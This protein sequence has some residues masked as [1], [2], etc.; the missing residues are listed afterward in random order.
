MERSP[1]NRFRKW[2]ERNGWWNDTAE[3]E[4]RNSVKKQASCCFKCLFFFYPWQFK[5]TGKTCLQL[6]QAIQ[7]AEK[8]EKPPLTELFTDVYDKPPANLEE[9]EKLLRESISKHPED[10]PSKVPT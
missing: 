10:Y 2:V 3:S 5:L 1:V 9:Q 4:L 7:A 8:T 6:L